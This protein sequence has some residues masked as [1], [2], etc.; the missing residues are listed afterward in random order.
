MKER[1]HLE[2]NGVDGKQYHSGS[3][4]NKLWAWTGLI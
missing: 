2:N 4:R 1:K 3:S